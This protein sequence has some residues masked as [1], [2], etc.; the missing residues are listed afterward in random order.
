MFID[1]QRNPSTAPEE[2]NV[3]ARHQTWRSAGARIQ[4]EA[5]AINIWPRRG[6]SHLRT[7]TLLLHY[8]FHE[9]V[10]STSSKA[11]DFTL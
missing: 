4:V 11:L 10:A 5:G 1:L 3:A 9:N 6:Q 2:P 8:A 7:N